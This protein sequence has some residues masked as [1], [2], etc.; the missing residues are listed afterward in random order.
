MEFAIHQSKFL[1]IIIII[2]VMAILTFAKIR[3]DKENATMK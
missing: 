1:I 2:G 3:H